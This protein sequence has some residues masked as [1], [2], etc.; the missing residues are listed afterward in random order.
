MQK[1]SGKFLMRPLL[2]KGRFV[3]MVVGTKGVDSSASKWAGKFPAD[4]TEIR[5][6]HSNRKTLFLLH[7]SDKL[8]C[9]SVIFEC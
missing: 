5:R 7:E 3:A 9:W 8:F 6:V 2:T 1:V 4:G